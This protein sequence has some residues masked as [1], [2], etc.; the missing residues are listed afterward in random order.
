M[1]RSVGT[2]LL[3]ILAVS[4][5]ALLACVPSGED[6]EIPVV[7]TLTNESK[8]PAQMWIG[9]GEADGAALLP[10]GGARE[11]N[12]KVKGK[13]DAPAAG[14]GGNVRVWITDQV[15][16]NVKDPATGKVTTAS[17]PALGRSETGVRLAYT[18][19]G[20]NIH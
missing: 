14:T 10:P 13:K 3:V 20:K 19:D 16:V 7:V 6:I 12:A 4:A 17:I 8:T 1:L 11:M 5:S 9:H 15:R 2:R 18:W